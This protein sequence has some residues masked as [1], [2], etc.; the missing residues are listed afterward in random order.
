MKMGRRWRVLERGEK[1]KQRK[2]KREKK[3]GGQ[4]PPR[5]STKKKRIFR[6][7]M[8]GLQEIHKFNKNL[9]FHHPETAICMVGEGNSQTPMGKIKVLCH[10][11]P[12]PTRCSGGVC[13]QPI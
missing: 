5:L 10:C 12:H 9:G 1:E 8:V 13:G 2:E 6:P 4:R 3:Q 7:G 11:P